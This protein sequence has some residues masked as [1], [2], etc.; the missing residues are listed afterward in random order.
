MTGD[1]REVRGEQREDPEAG[2]AEAHPPHPPPDTHALPPQVRNLALLDPPPLSH[3]HCLRPP[4]LHVRILPD[5][6]LL[7]GVG[8]EL[9][10]IG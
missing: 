7:G 1:P 10:Y 9:M 2:A 8:R 3:V 4:L 6:T 5:P